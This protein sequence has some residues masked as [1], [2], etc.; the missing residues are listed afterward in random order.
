M[1]DPLFS[2]IVPTRD[3]PQM[4]SDAVSS[5]LRQ[6]IDDIECIVV[7]DTGRGQIEIPSDPRIRVVDTDRPGG[8]AAARN[9]GLSVARGKYVT[10]LDD[11]DLLTPDR[12]DIALEGLASSK[13][14]LC[15]RASVTGRRTAPTWNATLQGDLRERILRGPIPHVGQVALERKAAPLFDPRFEV[16]EDVEWWVRAVMIGSATTVRRVGYLLREHDGSRQTHRL[17]ERLSHRLLLLSLHSDY[18]DSNRRAASY[19]WRRV[20]G[21]AGQLGDRA[22]ER[23]AFRRSLALYPGWRSLARLGRS[24]V[25]RPGNTHDD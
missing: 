11:D 20:G 9:T 4:L 14:A 6:S 21:F 15:W 24:Y 17:R 10:F 13:V 3:R 7:D 18:F 25:R 5:V 12:L 19:Q 8:T 16:S 2:I 23:E 22:L 1:S